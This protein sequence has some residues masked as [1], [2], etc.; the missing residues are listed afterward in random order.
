MRPIVHTAKVNVVVSV[1]AHSV[2]PFLPGFHE[3]GNPPSHFQTRN[4]PG[5]KQWIP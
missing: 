5:L 4:V 2:R 1:E 3:V